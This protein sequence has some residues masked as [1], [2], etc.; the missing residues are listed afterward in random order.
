M[1]KRIVAEAE[2]LGYAPNAV[3]SELM[4]MVR[5]GRQRSP[6]EVIAFI[7]TFQEDPT[8]MKRISSFRLF[9]EGAVEYAAQFGYIVE[10]FRASDFKR[11]PARLDQVLKA[12]GVRGVLVGPRWFDEPDIH[13]D[14]PAYSCVLVGETSYGAGIY[15]V[16][17]HHPQTVELALTRMAA[18]GYKR[19]GLELMANY[20][21][22][23]HFDHLAGVA[24]AERQVGEK[25][26]FFVRMN[27]DKPIPDIDQVPPEQR[28][29]VALVYNTEHRL[30]EL[31][32]WANQQQLDALVTLRGYEP[33]QICQITGPTGRPMGYA[34]LSVEAGDGCAGVDQHSIDIGRTA[35]DLLRGLLHS[36]N[37]GVVPRPRIVLVEG[38]WFDGPTAPRI[39]D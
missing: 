22:V 31:A 25:A 3:A 10:E 34:R 19:I 39:T 30:P 29:N 23:R 12:R 37:R 7:N 11:N 5:A 20:E 6:G 14:W 27:P 9:F 15:R 24:P 36:G 16:C 38:E 4:A 21:S 18:L 1:R 32:K 28:N 33:Q 26:R 35:L 17:N 13:L 2:R 8:L